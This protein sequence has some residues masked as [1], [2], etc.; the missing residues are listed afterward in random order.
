[1]YIARKGIAGT[2][3]GITFM[4]AGAASAAE[5]LADKMTFAGDLQIRQET[6][7]YSGD[8]YDGSN[9]NR[10][11]FRLRIGSDVEIGKSI[12][13]IRL[14][15]GNGSQTSVNQTMENFS[16]GKS[17]WIDRAYLEY[18]RMP[19]TALMAGRM[20]NPLFRNFTTEMI[21]DEDFN[22]EGFAE[23]V[24]H[25]H[26]ENHLLFVNLLQAVLDGGGPGGEAQW[27]LGYQAGGE[28]KGDPIRLNLAV[29]FYHL[30]NGQRSSFDQVAVQDGNTREPCAAPCTPVV[31]ANP[32][33]VIHGTASAKLNVGVPLLI[34][35]DV[36]KNLAD[37]EQSADIDG[38]ELA[39]SAGVKAGSATKA[40]GAELAYL[41]RYLET[42]STLADLTD[43]EYGPRGGTNREG[44]VVWVAY[45]L[46]DAAQIKLKYF[47]TKKAE[48]D[49]PGS[50]ADETH[51]RVQA[52]LLVRF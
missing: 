6:Q 29:L 14:A 13:H 34:S 26:G 46:S 40:H 28:I 25:L 19:H 18:L 9:V 31:L 35:A 43:S 48:E 10:Q 49:L 52:D 39:W 11:R 15:G 3:L 22:P 51:Q 17:I 44:H 1:M 16:S 20:A 37:T 47:N 8:D 41:Y 24:S 30:A 5:S 23:R 21:F 2:V 32:F 7:W 50:G 12:L 38:E 42:D 45:A 33:R 27:L 4:V 36:A